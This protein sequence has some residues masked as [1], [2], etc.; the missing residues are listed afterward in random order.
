MVNRRQALGLAL[1]GG[2]SFLTRH[3]QACGA[4]VFNAENPGRMS[5]QQILIAHAQGDS[6]V[7][8]S[9]G[10]SEGAGDFAF[11]F[12]LQSKPSEVRDAPQKLFDAL[13]NGTS[14]EII[15]HDETQTH[16]SG[17][18]CCGFT[19]LKGATGAPD[20]ASTVVIVERGATKTYDYAI[21]GGEGA[22]SVLDWLVK[23]G[24]GVPPNFD[25]AIQPYLDDGWLFLAAKLKADTNTGT[26]APLEMH[27]AGLS[28]DVLRY[29]LGLSGSTLPQG[30]R[31]SVSLYLLGE[32]HLPTNYDVADIEDRELR[33]TTPSASNYADVFE[34]RTN[35]G[36]FV[37]EYGNPDISL[38][39]LDQW[40]GAASNASGFKATYG[41]MFPQRPSLVRLRTQ[42]GRD[43][44]HDVQFAP[45]TRNI[46]RDRQRVVYWRGAP[47][48]SRMMTPGHS[49]ALAAIAL[50]AVAWARRR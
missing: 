37:L 40:L 19:G 24:F 13:D 45:A 50:G 47:T 7:T 12:P 29:P 16:E 46:A 2:A 49:G 3:A 44:L 27:F 35:D 14:P 15:I 48:A 4:M 36:A 43:Q 26:L 33:A 25:Q 18:G 17:G 41:P 39:F 42:L 22:E 28:I 5:D 32:A 20:G 21:V 1:F 34:D 23:E 9:V 38:E 31:V 8:V 11:L 30:K 6:V 10:Y